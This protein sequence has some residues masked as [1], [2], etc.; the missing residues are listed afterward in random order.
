MLCR[1]IKH[2]RRYI[3]K[4][5]P[6]G[7]YFGNEKSTIT[8]WRDRGSEM[9]VNGDVSRRFCYFSMSLASITTPMIRQLP[10]IGIMG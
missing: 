9:G 1:E 3:F 2:T 4:S 10:L 8:K 5:I 7:K 6:T